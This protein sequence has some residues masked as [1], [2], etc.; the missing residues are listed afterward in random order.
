MEHDEHVV[1]LLGELVAH[2]T[3][4]GTSNAALLDL[5]EGRLAAVASH[6][7][8]HGVDAH[9][10]NL[11]VRVGPEAPGGLVLA[12]HTDVVPPGEGWAS[13]PFTLRSEGDRLYA[14]GAA[15]MKGFLAAAV[16]TLARLDVQRLT[17]PVYLL[18]SYDE[19]VGCRGVRDV[20][21]A[22]GDLPP[23]A[24]VVVGEPTMMRPCVSH[25]GKRAYRVTVR[26]AE[27]HSSRA[28][29]VP[30]AIVHAAQLVTAVDRVLAG[31]PCAH[32]QSGSRSVPPPY[33]VNC[34][35]IN[36]GTATNVV[37]GRC[38]LTF[39]V[40][41]DVEHDPDVVL[42][43]VWDL[44]RESDRQLATVGGGVD[45]ECVTEYPAMHTDETDPLVQ[46]LV[47]L[48]DTGPVGHVGF[49]TE[50]GLY[51]KVLA[52]P[53]VVCGPGDIADAHRKD[54]YVARAQ[55]QRCRVVLEAL[56]ADVAEC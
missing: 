13:D 27:A 33:S 39:E 20:L 48:A 14:R 23:P 24:L 5:L 35:S 50:G 49:G 7:V 8:R 56:V 18:A 10:A 41:V 43:D 2:R 38:D 31:R 37:A 16:V 19:E 6:S 17:A 32:D 40:R 15:D 36:G 54:E 34:G 11:L 22:L 52:A 46:R 51:S 3:V 25:H 4:S 45:V 55:L 1:Q 30:S 42:R 9:R 28:G 26:G 47:R 44:V 53:V 21:P 29:A 12:G